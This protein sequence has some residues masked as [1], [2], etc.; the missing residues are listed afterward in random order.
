ML[1]LLIL[2]VGAMG[3]AAAATSWL[4]SRED[5]ATATVATVGADGVAGRLKAR[6]HQAVEEGQL[7]GERKERMLRHELA[8]FQLHPDRPGTSTSL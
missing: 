3:G 2:T 6:I 8:A 5:G 7:A 4:L 1:K